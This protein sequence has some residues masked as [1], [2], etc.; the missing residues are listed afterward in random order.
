[1]ITDKQFQGYIGQISDNYEACK[2]AI[3]S[4]DLNIL[5]PEAQAIIKN[6]VMLRDVACVALRESHTTKNFEAN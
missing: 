3:Y 6:L 4:S 5:S 1:M 2:D